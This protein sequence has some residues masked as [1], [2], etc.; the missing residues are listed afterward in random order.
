VFGRVLQGRGYRVTQ[1]QDHA[2]IFRYHNQS[3]PD[4]DPEGLARA[5]EEVIE[6]YERADLADSL[7][8]LDERVL[9]F[10]ITG[11]N[12]KIPL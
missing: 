11:N 6:Q 10:Y 12:V 9:A 2:G 8:E 4:D 5:V 7:V 3:L 1:A